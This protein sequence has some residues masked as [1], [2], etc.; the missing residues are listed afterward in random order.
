MG[1]SAA[2]LLISRINQPDLNYRTLYTET[3][4]IYRE[5]TLIKGEK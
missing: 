5:S 1:F 2:Q 3:D 4:L